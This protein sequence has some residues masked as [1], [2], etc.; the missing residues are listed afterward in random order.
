MIHRD[1]DVGLRQ[2]LCHKSGIRWHR[3]FDVHALRSQRGEHRND[4]VQLFASQMSVFAGMRIEAA[5]AQTRRS[6]AEAV[7]QIVVDDGQHLRQMRG[8]DGAADCGQR[9]MG[10]D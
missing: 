5:H 4:D 9:Q 3:A 7:A 6:D 1:D 10:G 8:G 2:M